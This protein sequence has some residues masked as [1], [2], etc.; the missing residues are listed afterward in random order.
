MRGH[1]TVTVVGNVG[2]VPDLKHIGVSQMVATF[3][4]AVNE[5]RV[6]KAGERTEHVSWIDCEAW[7]KTAE[8]V[9]QYVTEGCPIYLVGRLRQDKWTDESTGQKRSKLK[10]VADTF[11]VF[12]RREQT[13]DHERP[14]ASVTQAA[15][16]PAKPLS[17]WGD[18]VG[19]LTEDDIPF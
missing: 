8:S 15:P 19:P 18:E 12:N 2:R 6:N 17:Q 9:A 16:A 5:V 3:S 4:V 7:G 14:P 11:R 1:T 13:E 10:V